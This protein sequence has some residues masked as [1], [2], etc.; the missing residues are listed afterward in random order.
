M[1]LARELHAITVAPAFLCC[2]RWE[3]SGITDK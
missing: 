1:T 2:M 3:F